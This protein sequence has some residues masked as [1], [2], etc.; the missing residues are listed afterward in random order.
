MK[1]QWPSVELRSNAIDTESTDLDTRQKKT[2]LVRSQV[3]K[4]SCSNAVDAVHQVTG[5]ILVL[6]SCTQVDGASQLSMHYIL[7][8]LHCRLIGN[9]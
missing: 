5:Q 4:P 8:T 3:Y 7:G 9:V 1:W 2:K 6:N